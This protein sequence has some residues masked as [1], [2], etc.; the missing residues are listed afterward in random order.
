MRCW[1]LCSLL[2]GLAV[3]AS[4]QDQEPPD[5]PVVPQKLDKV[6]LTLDAGG[7]TAK[8]R[9]V[10]FTPDGKQV[11]TL[12]LDHTVRLWD[13]ETGRAVKVMYPPG[14]GG[15]HA[16]ALSPDG[17]LL[18]V[19][20]RYP[21]GNKL[22]YLIYVLTLPD[23]RIQ[24]V[25]RGHGGE[26]EALA[27][28]PDGRR[29]ASSSEDLTTRLWDLAR[30]DEGQRL[31]TAKN[32]MFTG[33]AFS[34]DGSRLASIGAS[35]GVL[36]AGILD[37]KAGKEAVALALDRM[38]A[39]RGTV[40]SSPPRIAWSPDGKTLATASW[41]GLQLWDP[42]GKLRGKMLA[43][44][45]V[46]S[47]AFSADSRTLL[48]TRGDPSTPIG[49]PWWT[50]PRPRRGSSLRPDPRGSPVFLA[51][52]GA[53]SPDGRL[54]ITGGGRDRTDAFIWKTADG[55]IHKHLA[56]PSWI[57]APRRIGAAPGPRT[58]S[59]LRSGTKGPNRRL[60]TWRICNSVHRSRIRQP[61]A[62][63]WNKA[64]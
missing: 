50:W 7:H 31:E 30:E 28:A 10:F 1:F 57:S 25:L 59:R 49:P 21:E 3:Q 33:L 23:G 52:D 26:I 4:A 14:A 20:S 43:G 37:L 36:Q 8:I 39:P 54:A 17:K 46:P 29:L 5:E 22:Q 63:S 44:I 45:K 16:A 42:D 53:F 56:A 15:L 35:N 19:G 51:L 62:R 27:F 2:L 11:I 41:S 55:T 64:T 34:P 24:R 9:K 13:V 61:A 6:T 48:A 58:A 38:D 12:G 18:A 60:S 32:R 40:L 47:V